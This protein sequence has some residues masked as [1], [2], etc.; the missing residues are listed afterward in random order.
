MEIY[1]ATL[2]MGYAM[3][4]DRPFKGLGVDYL[5]DIKGTPDVSKG[6]TLYFRADHKGMSINTAQDGVHFGGFQQVPHGRNVDHLKSLT[7]YVIPMEH[8]NT[9][10]Y[11][12]VVISE[13]RLIDRR[14]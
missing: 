4:Q 13:S 9:G 14:R 3:D 8:A 12:K 7:S 10:G 1:Y 11:S 6:L 5:Y 2:C